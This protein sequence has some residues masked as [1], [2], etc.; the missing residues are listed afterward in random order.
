MLQSRGAEGCARLDKRQLIAVVSRQHVM[1]STPPPTP[2]KPGTPPPPPPKP[3]T[4]PKLVDDPFQIAVRNVTVLAALVAYAGL[5]VYVVWQT[6]Q[7]AS[8]TPAEVPGVQS[9]A[10]GALAVAL[11]AGYAVILGVPPKE[12]EEIRASGFRRFWKWITAGG[13]GTVLLGLGALLYLV[14]G[15]VISATYAFNEAETPTV[16]STIAVGFGG[17]V[18]AYLGA[19]YSKVA[20][21]G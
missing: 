13:T 2:P 20:V 21:T 17:Y 19:A 11:G 9:A 18:I 6:W 5:A 4:P 14:V 7:A 8:G 12:E 16:L 1:T 3:S 15:I 10:L